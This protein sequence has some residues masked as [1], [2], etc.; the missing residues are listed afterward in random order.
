[1]KK[2]LIIFIALFLTINVYAQ[3]TVIDENFDGKTFPMNGWAE[4][5][6]TGQVTIDNNELE[7]DYTTDRP[8]AIL[9]FN[10]VSGFITTSF[11][12]KSTRNWCSFNLFFSDQNNKVAV[13]AIGNNET[14][15]IVAATEID[16]NGIPVNSVNALYE[17]F[18]KN[19][20]YHVSFVINTFDNTSALYIDGQTVP[21]AENIP[22]LGET[23]GINA[24]NFLQNYMYGDEG[25]VFI[26]DF[27][28]TYSTVNSTDFNLSLST[29]QNLLNAAVI[30]DNPGEYPQSAFDTF[31]TEVN[32]ANT[33]A[34]N[35]NITQQET[36][37]AATALNV[38][39]DIFR[40]N[41]HHIEAT[42]NF[43]SNSGHELTEGFSG[44]NVRITDTPWNFNHPEF[45]AAA[46]SMKPG[47]LR[48]FSGTL[49]DYFN[50]NTGMFEQEWFEPF[51][52][53]GE[54]YSK[55]PDIYKWMEAKGPHRLS[56]MNDMNG[57]LGSKLVITFNG[58]LDT[59]ENAANIAKFCKDNNIVVDS[60]QLC[61]EPNFYVPDNRY[62]F[63]DGKDYA[64]KQKE[65]ADAIYSIFPDAK[66]ALSYGWDNS[67]NFFDKIKL[68]GTPYWN[69][70]S[71]HSYPV[72]ATDA[73]FDEA[74]LR[75]NSR[76]VDRTDDAQFT[77]I[78]NN[79]W[80][81]APLLVTEYSVWN[82]RLKD[83]Y[84]STIYVA[85]YLTRMSSQPNSWMVGKHVINH[86]AYPIDT[87]EDEIMQA[88]AQGTQINVNE[89]QTRYKHDIE[90][91]G[92]IVVNEAI[93]NS[94]YA[95]TTTTSGGTSVPNLSATT[96]ALYAQAYKGI[97]GKQYW[98][99]INKSAFYHRIN[100][101]KDGS[102]I[103]E[104]LLMEYITSDN[105]QATMV[106]ILTKTINSTNGISVPPFSIIR[107]EQQAVTVPAPKEPRIYSVNNGNGSVVLK[108]W[109]RETADKYTIKYG[110]ASGSHNMTKEITGTENNS[111]E[112]TELTNGEQ[113]YFVVT[114]TNSEGE[115]NI[116]NEVTAKMIKP[117]A[118]VILSTH[119]LSGKVTV[120]WQS[121]PFANG[122]K[123]KYGST[124]GNYTETIDTKN[125]TGF[126]VRNLPNNEELFFTVVAYNGFGESNASN[127]MSATPRAK[128]PNCPYLI[129]AVEDTN[130]GTVTVNWTPSDSTHTG[131]F[132]LYRS[133]TPQSGYQLIAENIDMISYK[134]KE[135]LTTGNYYYR[136]KTEN[137]IGES[138]FYSQI[139]TVRKTI[140]TRITVSSVTVNAA[141]S[142]SSINVGESLQM[143]AV[144]SPSN[145]INKGVNWSVDDDTKA[146]I[147]SSGLLTAKATG[148][149][150]VTAT[151][152][153]N[154]EIKGTMTITIT[155]EVGIKMLNDSKVK[156][157][158]NPC[159]EILT[160]DTQAFGGDVN[161]SL[162]S[163]EGKI[164]KQGV[165]KD[166]EKLII[167][168]LTKGVYYLSLENGSVIITRKIV[169]N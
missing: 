73:N 49:G 144:I 71:L 153:E 155:T 34:S 2:T 100:L 109:L 157:Y 120:E 69:V 163:M 134:D 1:M 20:Y 61:N 60:W 53:K 28:I 102:A 131:T 98:V 117:D 47:F 56:D 36:D 42:I 75:A 132:K 135:Y 39:I 67:N 77:K 136:L 58:F 63:L 16:E 152:L 93:N 74:M 154:Q 35:P 30:G 25:Q 150:V 140:N 124:S 38:A 139:A 115:S 80:E 45:R 89:L 92:L 7:F 101:Q 148:D 84:Y 99:I 114:A 52:N 22:L 90:S 10:V 128:I 116:S 31:Q 161:Y 65:F 147:N 13:V 3:Q 142:I 146:N 125:V 105:P 137:D 165:V 6:T 26:D 32:L 133:Q 37:D 11:K 119:P 126:I 12:V 104:E 33:I 122:Y 70:V 121:V 127:E 118:P 50:M 15:G 145:A 88:Y 87:H 108:W 112:I 4:E 167:K 162:L 95:Y 94:D 103:S 8:K 55:I 166:I 14:K 82:D 51:T 24:V 64:T 123:V 72:H 62:F 43:E 129:N 164:I 29:A 96:P 76:L 83:K 113:Y 21:E 138:F 143:I 156:V 85:E 86:S 46:K 78:K 159:A 41:L 68:F 107:L 158:P 19:K 59:P 5:N 130:D 160:I 66:L 48:Y 54:D 110:T 81:N 91:I 23:D 97:N 141:N 18:Q 149:I 111:T 168:D 151:S 9:T 40:E 79:S 169:V 57:E 106:R 27:K 44:F 17:T